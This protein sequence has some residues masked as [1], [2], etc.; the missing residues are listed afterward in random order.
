MGVPLIL[1]PAGIA[2]ATIF[3]AEAA[4]LGELGVADRDRP[5]DRA[6]RPDR[7]GRRAPDRPA[8]AA[9][10]HARPRAAPRRPARGRRG[11]ADRHR[12]RRLRDPGPAR[13][14]L[15]V[16]TRPPRRRA[17]GVSVVR[18]LTAGGSPAS[19]SMLRGQL[20]DAGGPVAERGA[21]AGAAGRAGARAEQVVAAAGPRRTGR[22]RSCSRR[23][24]A[25]YSL[26]IQIELPS[27]AAAP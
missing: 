26:A 10:G 4:S 23:R 18:S 25:M 7:A 27:T 19:G 13:P 3:S 6:A 8:A 11:R 1:N 21:R 2:A 20:A 9:R 15:T 24:W 12:A 16:M 22:P 5:R 14:A 17:A